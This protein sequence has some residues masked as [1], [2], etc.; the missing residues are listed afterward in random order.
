MSKATNLEL[1]PSNRQAYDNLEAIT[2]RIQLDLCGRRIY[3]DP[4][5]MLEINSCQKGDEPN[6]ILRKMLMSPKLA[7]EASTPM[8]PIAR[9]SPWRLRA[10]ERL[11]G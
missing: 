4:E 1:S 3:G 2:T 9:R 6:L 5:A 10:I 8:A 11:K 7:R